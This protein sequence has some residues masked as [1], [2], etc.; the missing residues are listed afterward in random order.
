MAFSKLKALLR[1]AAK[2]TVDTLW[3]A[4]AEALK[5]FTPQE[6]ANMFAH[7]GYDLD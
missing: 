1:Q 4:V 3:D 5:A 6:C 7:A 2:R